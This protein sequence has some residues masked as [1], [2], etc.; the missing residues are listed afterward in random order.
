MELLL[1]CQKVCYIS[2]LQINY[3]TTGTVKQNVHKIYEKLQVSNKTEA[4]ITFNSNG[5]H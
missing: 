4:I 1:Y 5:G 3:I 2:K